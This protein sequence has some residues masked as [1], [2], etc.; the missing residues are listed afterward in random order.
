[1]ELTSHEK[2]IVR[3][4][5]CAY[6][7]KVLN[8]E[9]LNYFN[10]LKAQQEREVCFSELMQE[11]WNQLYACDEMEEPSYFQVLDIDVPVKDDEI[12]K[13][14]Q[15][16]PEKKRM[17]IL[18]KYFLDMTEKEIA[19]YLNLVQSTVHYHKAESL[20]LLKKILE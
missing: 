18:M 19:T 11:E 1:M 9:A 13:A 16:L 6:C 5:F 4:K 3:K 2:E 7:I 17:I 20:Q 15:L 12:S 14:L 10:E 8:G